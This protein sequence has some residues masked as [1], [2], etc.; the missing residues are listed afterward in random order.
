MAYRCGKEKYKQ[1]INYAIEYDE[2]A[3]GSLICEKAKELG[4]SQKELQR[5]F[6]TG[7]R[8]VANRVAGRIV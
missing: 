2:Y 3:R 6:D 5:F 4:I 7:K 1:D 8:P